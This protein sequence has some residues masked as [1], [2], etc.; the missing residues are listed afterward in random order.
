MP[1]LGSSS[2]S[3]S[4]RGTQSPQ[5][6][7]LWDSNTNWIWESVNYLRWQKKQK[8]I[9]VCQYSENTWNQNYLVLQTSSSW[10]GTCLNSEWWSAYIRGLTAELASEENHW[11]S[12]SVVQQISTATKRNLVTFRIKSLSINQK[13]IIHPIQRM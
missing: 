2:L 4:S 12:Q 5:M 9:S 13:M 11:K 7:L 6:S 3:P 8:E 1:W 10:I